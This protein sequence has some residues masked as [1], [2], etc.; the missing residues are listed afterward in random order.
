MSCTPICY[1]LAPAGYDA[2]I[3]TFQYVDNSPVWFHPTDG[4]GIVRV[5]T[6]PAL[7]ALLN[8]EK[9]EAK[10][11]QCSV[12][13]SG[14]CCMQ[15]VEQLCYYNPSTEESLTVAGLFNFQADGA[16]EWTNVDAITSVTGIS[17]G[18]KLTDTPNGFV[19]VPCQ[20]S[21]DA[22]PESNTRCYYREVPVSEPTSQPNNVA[23]KGYVE[24]T[25]WTILQFENGG[26]VGATDS[27]FA[28][29]VTYD[30]D[31]L[32]EFDGEYAKTNVTTIVGNETSTYGNLERYEGYIYSPIK[33]PDTAAGKFVK[34]FEL[35]DTYTGAAQ[36]DYS[37]LYVASD[38]GSYSLARSDLEL[39]SDNPAPGTSLYSFDPSQRGV[40]ARFAYING[41]QGGASQFNIQAKLTYDDGS[42]QT[43]AATNFLHKIGVISKHSETTLESLI[44]YTDTGE[45]TKDGEPEEVDTSLGNLSAAVCG[46]LPI[47]YTA[48]SAGSLVTFSGEFG[49]SGTGYQ[50][51]INGGKTFQSSPVFDLSESSA[52]EIIPMVKD[53]NGTL[54]AKTALDS[55]VPCVEKTWSVDLVSPDNNATSYDDGVA[56]RGWSVIYSTQKGGNNLEESD[57]TDGL[58]WVLD[59]ATQNANYMYLGQGFTDPNSSAEASLTPLL[60]STKV[61]QKYTVAYDL[62]NYYHGDGYADGTDFTVEVVDDVTGSVLGS[63]VYNWSSHVTSNQANEMTTFTGSG[64]PVTLRLK[65]ENQQSIVGDWWGNTANATLTPNSIIKAT[66][67]GWNTGIMSNRMRNTSDGVHFEFTPSGSGNK[68]MHGIDSDSTIASYTGMDYGFYLSSNNRWYVYEDGANRA[69]GTYTGNNNALFEIDV[70]TDG[71][72]TYSVNSVVVYTSAVNASDAD[73]YISSHPY[74]NGL[75][76]DNIVFNGTDA[77]A[78]PDRTND[79]VRINTLRVFEGEYSDAT[80]YAKV[81]G[82]S[83]FFRGVTGDAVYIS[84]SHGYNVDTVVVPKFD[85]R[86]YGTLDDA[87]GAQDKVKLEY[88]IGNGVWVTMLDHIG[89]F[90]A[91]NDIYLSPYYYEKGVSLA[92]GEEIRYRMTVSGNGDN[93]GYY[94][95]ENSDVV[96]C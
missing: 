38:G 65:V 58:T 78:I 74:S 83:V 18:D 64:N 41:D 4:D 93:D 30:V 17:V 48:W 21:S 87:V 12:L 50:Y 46:E 9:S 28:S 79:Y 63:R 23:G 73:Y 94:L 62:Y 32:P 92:A 56:S 44:L 60:G 84:D 61:G 77:L 47:S 27:D 57:N 13:S 10:V 82:D 35:V 26:N 76:I 90:D 33:Y 71:T 88:Q 80:H 66:G 42:T 22:L 59:N 67:N 96:R 86:R 14:G 11:V 95:Y 72:V 36:A 53:G 29:H 69:T 7:I 19:Q 68:G 49:G 1:D 75:G 52:I 40:H 37:Q 25:Q 24:K 70:A 5:V 45:W 81:S 51:S 20:T 39:V 91:A 3:Y 16:M 2:G 31:G 54:S 6:T 55:Y 34:S 43:L 8:T 85:I 89:T 15:Y